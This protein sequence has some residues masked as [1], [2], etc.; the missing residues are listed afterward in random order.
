MDALT[1][2]SQ[3]KIL[4]AND[5][6]ITYNLKDMN[7]NDR[8]LIQSL[9]WLNGKPLHNYIDGECCIDFS[10]CEPDLFTK[11]RKERERSHTNLI[12]KIN[13]NN[14]WGSLNGKLHKNTG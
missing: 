11:D 3:I 14:K 13:F 2:K 4:V 1:S 8:L 12:K 5:E 10:C 9:S 7:Y 6:F